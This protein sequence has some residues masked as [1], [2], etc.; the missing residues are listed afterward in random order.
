M[1]LS[2][3][4]QKRLER[5]AKLFLMDKDI[6]P[7]KLEVVRSLMNNDSLEN[8]EKYNV[9]IDLIKNCPDKKRPALDESKKV[10]AKKP[11]KPCLQRR[12]RLH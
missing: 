8:E 12:G 1:A 2:A 7:A 9:I 10:E 3:Q 4:E 11:K 5:K 6:P